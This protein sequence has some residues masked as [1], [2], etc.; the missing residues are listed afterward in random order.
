MS[1]NLKTVEDFIA[2]CEKRKEQLRGGKD[3][4]NTTY[5]A[6]ANALAKQALETEG[7]T[8]DEKS[9]VAD[10]IETWLPQIV[11]VDIKEV[12]KKLKLNALRGI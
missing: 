6:K 3:K 4:P 5:H 2:D 12:K 9:A 11:V 8:A 7:W 1:P 10:A